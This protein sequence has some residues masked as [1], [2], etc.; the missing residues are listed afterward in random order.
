M[1]VIT[2]PVTRSMVNVGAPKDTWVRSV[3]R[4]VRTGSMGRIAWNCVSAKMKDIV[5]LLPGN[6]PA[7]QDLQVH[8]KS[9]FP[10]MFGKV[11]Q[12]SPSLGAMNVVHKERTVKIV[13]PNVDAKMV[14]NVIQLV[15]NVP[16]V[17]L[18][19]QVP[20]AQIV[21][22][23]VHLDRIVVEPA[24]ASIRHRATISAVNVF[25]HPASPERSA[26]MRAPS[27]GMATIVP[28]F[29]SVKMKQHATRNRARVDASMAGQDQR[30]LNVFVH[31]IS[32]GRDVIVRANVMN[33]IPSCAI[34][35]RGGV[36]ASQVTRRTFVIV[37]AHS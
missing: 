30:V 37:H 33:K 27:I 18:V 19:G 13:A 35:G 28:K 16:P 21:A 2:V 29:V 34:R 26:L 36:N 22:Y 12:C 8:C 24:N 31:Q 6:V 20:L 17:L 32:T 5:I 4:N 23:P 9:I 1:I 3:I 15:E 25:A 10:K 7:S 11:P 14:E